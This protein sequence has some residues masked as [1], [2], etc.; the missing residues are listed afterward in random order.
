MPM[1]GMS[2]VGGPV[3]GMSMMNNGIGLG[4][5]RADS[6][7]QDGWREYLN[8]YI[9]DYFI[10]N[11]LYDCARA[12]LASEVPMKTFPPT[13][14]SPGRRRDGDVN[15]VDESTMDTDSK[16]DL[17]SKRPDDLPIPNVPPDCP[18]NSFLFDWWC[19]FWDIFDAQRGKKTKPG[20]PALQYVQHTQQQSRLRQEQQQQLL[21][22]MNPQMMPGQMNQ[23]QNLMRGMQ[24]NGMNLNQNELRQKA[25]QN[26]RNAYVQPTPQ[27][28]AQMAKNQQQQMMQQQ[29]Q[30]N[31]SDIDINGQ[32]PQSPSS[33]D[34]APS[35]SKRPRLEGGHFNGQQMGPNGMG[36]NGMG[37]N[38]RGQPPGMQG[39]QVGHNPSAMQA[40]ALLMQNG[41]NPNVL[42]ETQLNSFQ[43][44]NPAVQVKSIQ[45]YAQNLAQHQRSALNN[46]VPKGMQNPAGMPGQG[47]PMMQQGADPQQLSAMNDYY[48]GN[49]AQMRGMQAANGQGGN[50]ALQDYQMQLMLLE[51]QN[52]KRL[53]MARQEQDNQTRT[54][55]QPGVPGQS[56]FPPGM[57]PQG[58]RSGPSPNPNDQMKRGTPKMGQTGL[59]GSPL[60]DGSMPQGRGSPAAMNFAGQM[61]S[62]MPPQFFNPQMKNMGDGMGGVG[63]NG[64][65]MR[66]PSSHPGFNGQPVNPQHM[67]ALA[68]MQAGRMP[69]GNWQQGPQGQAPMMQ[70]TSQGQQPQQLGTPQQRTAMPPPQPP[71]AGGVSNGRTQPSSPQQVAAPPTPQPSNKTNPKGKK[72][73]KEPRKRPTKKGSTTTLNAAATPSEAEPPP[74]PTPS[75]PITPVH[76]NSFTG[77]KNVNGANQVQASTSVPASSAPLAP[78]QPDPNL[79]APFGSIDES[80][81]GLSTFTQFLFDD[82]IPSDENA[83][84]FN[85]ITINSNQTSTGSDDNVPLGFDF[86]QSSNKPRGSFSPWLEDS[87]FGDHV[88]PGGFGSHEDIFTNN[89]T[90][91]VDQFSMNYGSLD[92]EDVLDSF[93]F[94]SFLNEDDAQAA[95]TFDASLNFG[96]ADGVEAGAGEI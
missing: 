3:G 29:M 40:N 70:H 93:D 76:P 6:N 47:S 33:A 62:D 18:D 16:D 36:P 90:H 79:V 65:M 82:T 52:K 44:Q 24:A 56:G 17:H 12:F 11:E 28:M 41:I 10:K 58:S 88:V 72:D 48:T 42:S 81:V 94:R 31:G 21:R 59:P 85:D 80:D 77:Q 54:D 19:L 46:Q 89:S 61:P 25:L 30:R 20:D 50:H 55:G 87:V 96:N 75:T 69:N 64:P 15:G 2:A 53:M 91:Q 14:L 66:A 39:Q 7:P 35:P 45:V 95:F 1:A 4:A 83:F 51:Q 74:T 57:S 78:P 84:S 22:Q 13:K 9:Y 92:N 38:G 63:P 49:Q 32:R 26:S 8:T 71:P 37:P 68:R 23:Y 5:S 73:A 86:F 43:Q 60:P 27:Q 34:T 67:E